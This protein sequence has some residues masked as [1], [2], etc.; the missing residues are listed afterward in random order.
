[1]FPVIGIALLST[2]LGAGLR[3]EVDDIGKW[4]TARLN[5]GS[6]YP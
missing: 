1:M 2:T 5:A 3:A 6:R 4:G